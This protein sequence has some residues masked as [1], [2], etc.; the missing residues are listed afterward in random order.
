MI[1]ATD[2][3]L[4]LAAMNRQRFPAYVSYTQR[5]TASTSG[6]VRIFGFGDADESGTYTVRTS[7]GVVVERPGTH[8]GSLWGE[9]SR[10]G[11]QESNPVTHPVFDLHCY[12]PQS[13]ER[14]PF[15]GR[16]ALRFDLAPVR[17][18][19]CGNADPSD[20]DTPFTTLY[21]DPSTY[22][23]LGVTGFF[24][25][26]HVKVDLAETFAT[27]DGRTLPARITVS[28]KGSG[29]MFWLHVHAEQTYE[30]YQFEISRRQAGPSKPQVR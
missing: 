1:A 8:K 28:I 15:N 4:V 7:D 14:A 23:P 27:I 10:G 19:T 9:R 13:E 20:H 3:A 6:I 24:N 2:Y 18:K 17:S 5:T 30:N 12:V 21:A 11:A 25:D 22:R 16:E 26:S 29:L